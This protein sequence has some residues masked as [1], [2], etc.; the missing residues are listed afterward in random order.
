MHE[1]EFQEFRKD[2]IEDV[3]SMSNATGDGYTATFAAEA[4]DQLIES[5]V[6]MDYLPSFYTDVWK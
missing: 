3:R 1:L 6:L 2:F 5:E 4:A